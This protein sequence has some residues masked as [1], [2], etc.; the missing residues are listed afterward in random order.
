[1]QIHK[2]YGLLVSA[3]I[4]MDCLIL[5]EIPELL[6]QTSIVNH[7]LRTHVIWWL[8]FWIRELRTQVQLILGHD[9]AVINSQLKLL[10]KIACYYSLGLFGQ[11]QGPVYRFLTEEP[12]I[13]IYIY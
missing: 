13:Y 4:D 7:S 1:M 8:R 9:E 5:E 11:P 2:N 3:Y 6:S 12:L 10:S